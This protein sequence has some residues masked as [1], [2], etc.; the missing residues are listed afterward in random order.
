[1]KF[2]S[3]IHSPLYASPMDFPCLQV[4]S[5]RWQLLSYWTPSAP[6][7]GP[8]CLESLGQ[9]NLQSTQ[10]AR[11]YWST[12]HV[13]FLRQTTLLHPT[14]IKQIILS[15]KPTKRVQLEVCRCETNWTAVLSRVKV[16]L[17]E[18]MAYCLGAEFANGSPRFKSSSLPLVNNITFTKDFL[19]HGTNIYPTV[20]IKTKRAVATQWWRQNLWVKLQK[21]CALQRS[22]QRWEK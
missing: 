4:C 5:L 8:P 11:M 13:R 22:S 14:E 7:T 9:W 12:M 19:I 2:Y 1:M 17:K 20:K 3:P 10:Y 18:A 6:H 21:T 15:F 16:P